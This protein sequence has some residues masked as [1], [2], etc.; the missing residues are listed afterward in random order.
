MDETGSSNTLGPYE[1]TVRRQVQL[2][3]IAYDLGT[4]TCRDE[5]VYLP[6]RPDFECNFRSFH[7]AGSAYY[8]D[9]GRRIHVEGNYSQRDG[10]RCSIL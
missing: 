4:T 7:Y 1:E 3:G 8:L 6:T 5:V 10:G 9:Y 2:V